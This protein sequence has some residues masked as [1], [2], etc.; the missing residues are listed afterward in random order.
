[1]TAPEKTPSDAEAASE[2]DQP[3]WAVIS[4]E[5]TEVTGL[6][7][8]EASKLLAELDAGG[9]HGLALITAEAAARL[10]T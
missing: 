4:F 7:Y 9:V 5:K 3:L 1:M 8:A 6:T 10:N 2:L